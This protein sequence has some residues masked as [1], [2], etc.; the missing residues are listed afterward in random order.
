VPADAV[1]RL[2]RVLSG[3]TRGVKSVKTEEK[4]ASER[5]IKVGEECIK[6]NLES[7]RR[8]END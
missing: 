5:P 4:Y 2:A 6:T 3:I 7:R 1:K 8:L